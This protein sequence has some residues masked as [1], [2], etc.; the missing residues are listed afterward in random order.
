MSK[1]SLA[2]NNLRAAIIL[3]VLT[4]HASLAYL[5]AATPSAFDKTPYLWRAFPIVDNKRWIGLDIFCAWQDIA[6]MVLL[7][8]LSA[9]FTWPSLKRK[10]TRLFLADRLLRLGIPFLFGV[11]VLMP[12]SLYAAYLT[13]ATDPSVAA[14]VHHL[15]A[16]PFWDSGPMWFLAQLLALTIV[17]AALHGFAP[18]SVEFLGDVSARAGAHPGKYFLVLTLAAVVAYVPM[19]LVFG[20]MTWSERG[21]VSFQLCRPL[22]YL[23]FYLAGLGV[24][25]AGFDKGLL[26]A[27]GALARGWGCWLAAGLGSLASWLGLMGLS[28]MTHS[29]SLALEV[30]IAI[31]FAITAS[32]GCMAALAVTVRFAGF[33]SRVL[34]GLSNNAMGIYV[35]H[36]P[37]S[38]WLQF[39]L[40]GVAL[41]AVAKAM[42]VLALSLVLSMALI[43]AL[44]VVP[45][46]A[47]L[48]GETPPPLPYRFPRWRG[49]ADK[50]PAVAISATSNLR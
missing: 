47:Y 14:Y 31:V 10:G 12:I 41:F 37:F 26:A 4:V 18:G 46:G 36:Y 2:L 17:A 27:D 22:F 49:R 43:L 33:R 32:S 38:V 13:R 9:L 24:G 5:T 48:V 11:V 6:L 35:V 20:P 23:V 30:V 42:I 15:L 8:F 29:Q 25:A 34:D 28:L 40:L 39:A 1:T 45:F 3:A 21:P 16:L 7:F 19:A 50:P 44:R